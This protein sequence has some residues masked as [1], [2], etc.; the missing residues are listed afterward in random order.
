V[1]LGPAH[2]SHR[3]LAVGRHALAESA[4]AA[5]AVAAAATTAATAAASAIVREF[6]RGAAG[7]LFV[8][9]EQISN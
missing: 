2:S 1:K 6:A 7:A 8:G 3:L 9:R 5:A 4:T